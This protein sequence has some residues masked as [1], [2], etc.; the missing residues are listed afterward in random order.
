ME[1]WGIPLFEAHP[2]ALVRY[3]AL[4]HVPGDGPLTVRI[5]GDSAD[6][7]LW[8]PDARRVP[9][10]VFRLSRGWLERTDD[11]LRSVRLRLILDLNLVT[12][13]PLRAAAWA[14]AALAG[15]R[16]GSIA[17]FEVG[18]EP[19]LYDRAYW[20]ATIA[21]HRS[22][23]A[24]G[25]LAAARICRRSTPTPGPCASSR[26]AVPLMGPAVAKPL[27]SL[28]FIRLLAVNARAELGALTAHRYPY[29]ACSP[30]SSAAFPTVSRLLSPAAVTNV[31][32]SVGRRWRWR[33]QRVCR[34]G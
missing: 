22:R 29:S 25:D 23:A 27:H 15:L 8:N 24:G 6:Q 20:L 30:P 17:A 4:L 32:G 33:T 28:G 11:L 13:S 19:D 10:W 9:R 26:P 21:A 14:R 5:G 18:N 34:C 7:S 12:A 3:L 16:P 31:A 2:A 1:Y